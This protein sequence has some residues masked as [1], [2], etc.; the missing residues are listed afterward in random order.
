MFPEKLNC[1]QFKKG[2]DLYRMGNRM[3]LKS[4]G[5]SF[6]HV[7]VGRF[8]VRF[9]VRFAVKSI[10]Q[11]LVFDLFVLKCVNRPL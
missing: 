5:H 4:H 2:A 3:C 1:V 7:N 9:G 8:C 10:L 11:N 6:V